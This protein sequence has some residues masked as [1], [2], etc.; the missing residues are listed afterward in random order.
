[1]PVFLILMM[2]LLVSRERRRRTSGLLPVDESPLGR[3][4]RN[5]LV[6]SVVVLALGACVAESLGLIR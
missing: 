2:T 6:W 4:L 3:Q 1:M 5:W